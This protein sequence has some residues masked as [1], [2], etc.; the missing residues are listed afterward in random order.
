MK[1]YVICSL[2]VNVN[3][4]DS[5]FTFNFFSKIWSIANTNHLYAVPW[6]PPA[7][8]E[9]ICILIQPVCCFYAVLCGRISQSYYHT[10][11]FLVQ[12]PSLQWPSLSSAERTTNLQLRNPLQLANYG[13]EWK[14]SG[15][16]NQSN[17]IYKSTKR[18]LKWTKVLYREIKTHT[19]KTH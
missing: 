10:I 3:G 11:L 17:F 12:M 5:L 1:G 4:S 15:P 7:V 8:K 18:T 13:R 19:N 6:A 9:W 16:I 2:N 14:K